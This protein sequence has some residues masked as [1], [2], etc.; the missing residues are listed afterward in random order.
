LL[1][2][3]LLGRGLLNGF[4]LRLTGR[5]FLRP[6]CF[7][8][9]LGLGSGRCIRSAL[10]FASRGLLRPL[11]GFL[12]PG[13]CGG[14][15]RLLLG[16]S[17]IGGLLPARRIVLC[18]AAAAGRR[19]T[20]SRLRL[21]PVLT[22]AL[23]TFGTPTTTPSV[24]LRGGVGKRFGGY[25]RSERRGRTRERQHRCKKQAAHEPVHGRPLYETR[26]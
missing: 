1:G 26:D 21:R 17:L 3:G 24:V 14:F 13:R 4:T 18:A 8:L 25:I 12:R 11:L 19:R 20:G 2:R 10:S 6:L 7:S 23:G 16:G 9:G 22:R 15:L 5:R